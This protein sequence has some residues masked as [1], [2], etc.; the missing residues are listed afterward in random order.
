MQ[1]GQLTLLSKKEDY[2]QSFDDGDIIVQTWA[3][4]GCFDAVYPFWQVRFSEIMDGVRN[5]Y[6]MPVPYGVFPHEPHWFKKEDIKST[7]LKWRVPTTEELEELCKSQKYYG[8]STY[9]KSLNQTWNDDGHWRFK[10]LLPYKEEQE[11]VDM[12]KSTGVDY[13]SVTREN[14]EKVMIIESR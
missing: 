14:F 2:E 12:L 5:Y 9:V 6:C 1:S 8:T 4:I 3:W 7:G 11:L 10:P 13:T